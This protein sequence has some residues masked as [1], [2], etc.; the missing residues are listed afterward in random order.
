M[1]LKLINKKKKYIINLIFKKKTKKK[2]RFIMDYTK[3][4]IPGSIALL[5]LI[6]LLILTCW[7]TVDVTHYGLKCNKFSK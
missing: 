2:S 6:I 7:D 1:K 5:I 3:Y 4:L